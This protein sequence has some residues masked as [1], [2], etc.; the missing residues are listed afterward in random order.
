MNKTTV[1]V[2]GYNVFK[3]KLNIIKLLGSKKIINTINPHSYC[4][5]LQD[6]TFKR[7]LK[8]SDIL[9]PDGIGICF[10]SKFLKGININKIAGAD[11]HEFLLREIER[12]NGKIFYL[13]ASEKTLKLIT[14]RI[15]IE[16]PNIK[17][18]SYSPPYKSVFSKGDNNMMREKVNLFS[19]DV[20]FVGMTAPKQ[21]K[22][23]YENKD[24]L[25]VN[26]IASIGAVFDFYAGTI[27]RPG[28]L[29]IKLGL[30][31]LPR[32]CKEP[33]RLWKRN[34]IST[35]LFLY[36]ILKEKLNL[37]I[38]KRCHKK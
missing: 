16:Y 32:L 4:V 19:P 6:S 35:P 37:I 33:R 8:K 13:G 30:E 25:R 7:A 26:M 38:N 20:L 34:F 11:I 24:L 5:A 10:A 3:G 29:W 22:W 31:W 21:E 18:A 14:E 23:V 17:L 9:L 15:N 36:Y 27:K 2:L 1:E 12:I 28:K